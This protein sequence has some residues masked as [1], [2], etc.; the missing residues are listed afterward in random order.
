ML[1]FMHKNIHYELIC[2]LVFVGGLWVTAIFYKDESP[3]ATRLKAREISWQN[4]R[5]SENVTH[6]ALG[7]V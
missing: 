3:S 6:I 2:V 1:I 7:I 5:N 4:M